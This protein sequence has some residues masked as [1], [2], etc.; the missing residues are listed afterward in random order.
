MSYDF[1]QINLV[2]ERNDGEEMYRAFFVNNEIERKPLEGWPVFYSRKKLRALAFALE[3]KAEGLHKVLK[4][5]T[6]LDLG[7]YPPIKDE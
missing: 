2:V 6:Y 1:R 4:E 3:Y 7:K 5:P